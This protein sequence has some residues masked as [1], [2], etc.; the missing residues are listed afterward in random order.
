MGTK[1]NESKLT[2]ASE[3]GIEY[4]WFKAH[5]LNE[6]LPKWLSVSPRPNGFLMPSFDESWKPTKYAI[7]TLT[8]QSRLLYNFSIGYELTGEKEYFDVV[9][10]GAQFLL[11]HF[12]DKEYGGWVFA[13]GPDGKV[14]DF[15]KNS[16]AH[17]FAILGFSHVYHVTKL[18]EY[19][20]AALYTWQI[21][22]SKFRDRHG[23]FAYK[24]TRDFT[25]R[26][27]VREQGPVMH[28]FEALL[29]LATLCEV[30]E[31]VKEAE[32]IA[33]FVV[34]NL[35]RPGT[36]LLPET[37]SL[38]WRVPCEDGCVWIGHAFEWAYL[39]SRGV[40]I[41]LPSSYLLPATKLLDYGIRVGYDPRD[42][43][44]Y[45]TS[46][47]AG[48]V[49]SKRKDWWSQCEAIRALLHFAVIRGRDELYEPLTKTVDFVKSDFIDHEHGGWYEYRDTD[50]SPTGQDKGHM[51]ISD[52]K[53][54]GLCKVD[55]HVVGMCVEAL[56]IQKIQSG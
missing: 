40:E 47:L 15:H 38:D 50:L 18:N 13:C 56:R 26:D 14:L 17:A 8:T 10:R 42:G 3:K 54:V 36:G 43:G 30:S 2:A 16:Y 35:L 20:E 51:G 46:S 9:V 21:L 5:L 45:S 6:V 52:H 31:A 49:T 33:E 1:K 39:L 34:T 19:K 55:Y 44:V 53:V 37:Y 11:E 27:T 24:M 4:S 48:E 29:A 41:G 7:S 28:L 22:K 23:G 25:D 12:K 32:F